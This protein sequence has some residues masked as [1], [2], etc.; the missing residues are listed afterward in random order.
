[1]PF[2]FPL[3]RSLLHACLL[4]RGSLVPVHCIILPLRCHTPPTLRV[5]FLDAILLFLHCC[6]YLQFVVPSLFTWIPLQHLPLPLD[7]PHPRPPTFVLPD[8]CFR[9]HLHISLCTRCYVLPTHVAVTGSYCLHTPTPVPTRILLRPI[10]LQ[11]RLP[12]TF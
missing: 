11:F 1:M 10:Y 3:L 6:F 7:I 9:F 2:L 12:A 5:T 4:L 8:Y